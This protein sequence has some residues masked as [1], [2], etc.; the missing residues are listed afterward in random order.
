MQ[1][2]ATPLPKTKTA[3]RPLNLNINTLEQAIMSSPKDIIPLTLNLQKNQFTPKTPLNTS[4]FDVENVDPFS[5]NIDSPNNFTEPRKP[6][7]IRKPL[8]RI[9]SPN[10]DGECS[11]GM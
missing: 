3:L 9:R 10:L 7:S 1:V 2:D 5:P 11:P 8:K 6:S 4:Q